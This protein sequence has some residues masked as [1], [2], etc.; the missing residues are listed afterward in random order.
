M[1]T[2]SVARG[3]VASDPVAGGTVAG[4]TVAG[5]TVTGSTATGS[6]VAAGG[7]AKGGAAT[8]SIAASG[9]IATSGGGPAD[10]D[11]GVDSDV[12]DGTRQLRDIEE[13]VAKLAIVTKQ[14]A[15]PA[16]T[17]PAPR[18]ADAGQPAAHDN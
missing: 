10:A 14:L 8:G 11:R 1:T 9:S 12:R 7:T 15:L 6:T 2:G 13:L 18:Y 17:M 5:S 3:T 16:R 4:S